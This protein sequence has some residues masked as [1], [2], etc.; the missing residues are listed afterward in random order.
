MIRQADTEPRRQINL[1]RWL[2]I[3]AVATFVLFL[4]A[5]AL[6]GEV[7][8]AVAFGVVAFF[9]FL[10]A[11]SVYFWIALVG[12]TVS[13]VFIRRNPV[14]WSLGD[15]ALEDQV[16][17][18]DIDPG[19]ELQAAGML[20]YR[21]GEV[22]PHVYFRQIPLRNA[23]AV[24]PFVVART[25][26]AR[27][28]HF[29]FTLQNEVDQVFL[30]KE[31]LFSLQPTPQFVMP[32][33]RLNI[34]ETHDLVGQSWQLQVRSGVTVITAVRFTF[35]EGAQAAAAAGETDGEPTLAWQQEWLPRL[36][37][38]TVKQ[39]AMKETQ[40]IVWEGL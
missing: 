5:L 9:G 30:R 39:D 36:L 37:D 15:E 12:G 7:W 8:R 31:V 14:P 23:R 21:F 24:R 11:L 29:E 32:A 34:S 27:P 28:Y 16:P 18:H 38:E 1:T 33:E 2:I 4:L 13:L 3:V 22:R 17:E 26:A 6:T 25:G 19:L 35:V 20:V 40:E 10:V